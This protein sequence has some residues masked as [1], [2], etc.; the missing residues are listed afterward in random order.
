MRPFEFGVS[1]TCQDPVF[2]LA[3]RFPAPVRAAGERRRRRLA[4]CVL[5]AV[6]H[7]PDDQLQLADGT[8]RDLGLGW[9]AARIRITAAKDSARSGSR[10]LD[11]CTTENLAVDKP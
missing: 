6:S 8:F 5:P 10:Q 1:A 2:L 3:C 11:C 7:L 4:R 9:A